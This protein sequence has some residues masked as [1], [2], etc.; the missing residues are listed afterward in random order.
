VP[1]EDLVIHA[2]DT[3]VLSACAVV[4]VAAA[5]R[6]FVGQFCEAATAAEVSNST[7]RQLGRSS[8]SWYSLIAPM[9]CNDGLLAQ[10]HTVQQQLY[11]PCVPCCA[12]L[13]LVQGDAAD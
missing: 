6:W 13:A 8:S 10:K 1:T 3:S 2:A 7:G 9:H 5:G 12:V 11:P 4:A